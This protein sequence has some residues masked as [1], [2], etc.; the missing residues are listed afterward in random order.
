MSERRMP[1]YMLASEC[2]RV[3]QHAAIGVEVHGCL[4]HV[5][6]ITH[7]QEGYV[8]CCISSGIGSMDLERVLKALSVLA[9]FLD[10]LRLRLGE[11]LPRISR[12]EKGWDLQWLS[13]DS[14]AVIVLRTL[15][16]WAA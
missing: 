6:L 2:P 5:L 7:V 8:H 3:C 11:W 16:F 9:D 4:E 13:K 1:R 15:R 10:G 12:T 14:R